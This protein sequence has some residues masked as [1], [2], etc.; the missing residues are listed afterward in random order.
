MDVHGGAEKHVAA[1]C[2]GLRRLWRRRCA[3]RGG[4]VAR[5]RLGRRRWERQSCV[6]ERAA[7]PGGAV[8]PTK[9]KGN[10]MGSS[11]IRAVR[12]VD[13]G[14]AE[15]VI[16]DVSI[17]PVP[18]SMSIFSSTSLPPIRASTRASSSGAATFEGM[19]MGRRLGR[20]GIGDSHG[21]RRVRRLARER[22]VR[23]A[24]GGIRARRRGSGCKDAD[25]QV[26]SATCLVDDSLTKSRRSSRPLRTPTP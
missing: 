26:P 5:L 21:I 13:G 20:K 7:A 23:A 3:R 25:S 6:R 16:D 8:G 2:C 12:H 1:E 14:D 15:A 22:G 11:A 10:G 17:Q 9:G 18:A 19:L 4:G 24:A